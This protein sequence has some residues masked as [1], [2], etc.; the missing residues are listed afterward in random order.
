LFHATHCCCWRYDPADGVLSVS[1]K[2]PGILQSSRWTFRI[3]SL[4]HRIM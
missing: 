2:V 3:C 1:Y 4:N